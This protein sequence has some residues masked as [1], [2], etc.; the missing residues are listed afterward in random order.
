MR[1]HRAHPH[2]RHRPLALGH[3]DVHAQHL[4]RRGQPPRDQHL[5]R[6]SRPPRRHIKQRPPLPQHQAHRDRRHAQERRLDRR[7]DRP[8]VDHVDPGVRPRVHPRNDQIRSRPRAKLLGPQ[9]RNRQFHA[10]RRPPIHGDPGHQRVLPHLLAAGHQRF[11]KRHPMPRRRLHRQRRHH[12][13]LV[14]RRQRPVH[15]RD[16]RR[17]DAI[18]VGQQDP[19]SRG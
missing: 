8:R 14:P 5:D 6:P 1:V 13:D 2:R 7:G 10:V 15:R 4:V 11:F 3:R 18:V 19:H 17:P 16:P 12:Q 9:A